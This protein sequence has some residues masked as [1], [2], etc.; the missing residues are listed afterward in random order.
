MEELYV[1]YNSG[2]EEEGLSI[3][4]PNELHQQ[5]IYLYPKSENLYYTKRAIKKNEVIR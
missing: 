2:M 1:F 5:F 4:K 3:W